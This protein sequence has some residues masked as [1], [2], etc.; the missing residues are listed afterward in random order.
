MTC[1]SIIASIGVAPILFFLV[2]VGVFIAWYLCRSKSLLQKWA[3][4]NGY[5]ILHS[6]FGYSGNLVAGW[7]LKDKKLLE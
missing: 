5:E 7:R 6:E 1:V 2:G 3:G 4:V